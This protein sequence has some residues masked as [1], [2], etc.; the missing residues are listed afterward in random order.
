[1][2][3][4]RPNDP[5][6]RDRILRAVL[7]V[8]GDEGLHATSYRRVAARAG[9]PLG[10]VTYYFTDLE[11]L[12]ASAFETLGEGLEP[13]Y[14]KPLRD[15]PDD[16][17]AVEALV[18]ATCGATSP[19]RRDVRLYTEMYHYAARSPRVAELVRAFQE[20]SLQVLRRRFSDPAARA[21]DA[22]V[23]GWWTYRSFHDTP[24]D[25]AMV[26]R[27]FEALVADLAVGAEIDTAPDL[28]PACGS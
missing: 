6:R 13:R 19:S 9:V 3:K 16:T 20:E 1:V 12:I 10:S 27:A 17:E 7:A 22:L 2:R 23:W 15:A 11:T 21:V 14:A 28:A 4:G 26:R 5:Q 24:L 25:E 8:I 18:A